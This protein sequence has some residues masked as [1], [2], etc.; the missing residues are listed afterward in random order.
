MMLI[1]TSNIEALSDANIY[2]YCNNII[3][4]DI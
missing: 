2:K 1:F 4:G 3:S